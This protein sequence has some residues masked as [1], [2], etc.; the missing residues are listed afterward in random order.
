MSY[1]ILFMGRI[2]WCG[3][4]TIALFFVVSFSVVWDWVALGRIVSRRVVS[5]CLVL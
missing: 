5:G 2:S 1:R 3:V 4:A